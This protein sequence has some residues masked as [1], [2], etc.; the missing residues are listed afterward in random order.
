MYGIYLHQYSTYKLPTWLPFLSSL[1][2][3]VLVQHF[4]KDPILCLELACV[5][6]DTLQPQASCHGV[7]LRRLELGAEMTHLV[8]KLVQRDF[9]FGWHDNSG[10]ARSYTRICIYGFPCAITLCGW[11]GRYVSMANPRGLKTK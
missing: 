10:R 4:N 2:A 6:S 9:C 7:R 5:Q 8:Q 3:P 1:S 11:V